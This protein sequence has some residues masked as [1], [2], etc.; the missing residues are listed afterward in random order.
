MSKIKILAIAPD[1]KGVGRIRTFQPYTLLNEQFSDEVHVTIKLD[2][3]YS[4]LDY[5]AQFDFIHI[6]KSPKNIKE[7]SETIRKLQEKGCI[8]NIDIDDYWELPSYHGLFVNWSQQNIGK[9]IVQNLKQADCVSTTTNFFAQ[10]I[11]KYNKNVY[12]LPNAINPFEKQFQ[13]NKE[14]NERIRF[15]WIGGSNHK[16][17][18]EPIKGMVNRLH[19]QR[20]QIQMVL[21]G[22]DTSGVVTYFNREKNDYEQRNIEPK[23]SHSYTYENFFTDNYKLI[24]DYPIYKNFLLQFDSQR[25]FDDKDLPYRRIWTKQS[26]RYAEFYNFVDVSLAPLVN[27]MFNR[28]KSNIKII[29]AGFFKTPIIAQELECYTEDIQHGE[30]GFLVSPRKNHK[31]WYNFVKKYLNNPEMIHD[32]G[33]ALYETVKDDYNLYNVNYNRLEMIQNQLNN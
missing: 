30:N 14:E 27:N 4:D 8:V 19:G 15:G 13:I 1:S 23:E 24:N 6:H 11:R 5:F 25:D 16:Q 7:G 22:F 9:Y 12:V 31:N 26:H 17:D 18:L 10:Q 28:V 33:M 29:E 32:H 21:G 2:I 20:N 3:D